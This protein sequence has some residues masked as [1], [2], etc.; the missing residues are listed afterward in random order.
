MADDKV[1]VEL[2]IEEQQALKAITA[3]TKKMSEF[4][5]TSE[6]S[7]K[8]AS[9]QMDQFKATMK[10]FLGAQIIGRMTSGL[11]NGFG[12]AIDSAL[13]FETALTEIQTILPKT[14]KL[15]EQQTQALEDLGKQY[16]TSATEQAKAYY[17]VISAGVTDATKA[18]SLLDNANKLA[19]GGIS[20]VGSSIDILTS[21][22]N[23]YGQENITAQQSADSLFSTVQLGK[24]TVS[25]LASSLAGVLPSA[26]SAGVGLD[27]VNSSIAV[28]TTNGVNTSESVTKL[29]ALF[30]SLAM[31]S[32]ELGAG[33]D[34]SAVKSDGLVTVLQ[35]LEKRTGGNSKELLNLLGRQE[36]VDAAQILM[37]DS[38]SALTDTYKKVQEGVGAADEAFKKFEKNSEF[39]IKRLKANAESIGKSLIDSL[40]PTLNF[41]AKA[42]NKFLNPPETSTLKAVRDEVTKTRDRIAELGEKRK[43]YENIQDQSPKFKENLANVTSEIASQEKKLKLLLATRGEFS[44]KPEATKGPA[45]ASVVEAGGESTEDAVKKVSEKERLKNEAILREKQNLNLQLAVLEQEE[46]A[47]QVELELANQ[48]LTEEERAAKLDQLMQFEKNKASLVLAQ[49]TLKTDTLKSQE[50]KDTAIKTAEVQKRIAL[51]KAESESAKRKAQLEQQ[52]FDVRLQALQG[53]LS[54]GASLAKKGSA[55]QKAIQIANSIISTY[56][57][58]T[59]ALAT[60]P[61][62]PYTIPLAG[63]VVAQG[64]ANVN[65]IANQ[66]FQ[67]GGVVGGFTGATNGG[68]NTIANVRTGEMMLNANQQKELFDIAKG[69]GEKGSNSEEIA[70]IANRPIIVEIDGREIARTVRNQRLE[71]FN[72]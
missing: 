16:G 4:G 11:S 47:R 6:D 2:T 66:S 36:A 68:D 7:A 39:Q 63:A 20:D 28:M 24:T 48:T 54:A 64:L 25:E 37:R 12:V 59:Q 70:A 60:P 13:G 29:R 10:G 8:R 49:A 44:K 45:P 67:D 21:I 41:A 26:R 72:I 43:L 34:I 71:G 14:Q 31:K 5:D 65:R 15:T 32:K 18:T 1:S 62:P 22:V 50:A 27:L 35:R 42:M 19:V 58:A 9:K 3:L 61:G 53:Y 23:S 30:A 69:G 55:A 46:A 33:M 17:Q 57:A 38:A 56:S 52:I 51:D 40:V